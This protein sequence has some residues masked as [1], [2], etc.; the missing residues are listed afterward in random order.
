MSYQLTF[1]ACTVLPL[2]MSSTFLTSHYGGIKSTHAL[3]I[4]RQAQH[5]PTPRFLIQELTLS[6]LSVIPSTFPRSH[7][8]LLLNPFS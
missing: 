4:Q 7:S 3:P 8:I 2:L 1:L 6:L 5:V